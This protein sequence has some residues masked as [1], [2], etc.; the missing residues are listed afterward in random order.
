MEGKP[1]HFD[2][3]VQNDLTSD[4]DMKNNEPFVLTDEMRKVISGN[5][6]SVEQAE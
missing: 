2:G 4:H 6:M 1:L 5:P 3:S